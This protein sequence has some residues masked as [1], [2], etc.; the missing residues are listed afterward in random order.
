VCQTGTLFG[1]PLELLKYDLHPDLTLCMA[2]L[3]DARVV[4]HRHAHLPY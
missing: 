4:A 1:T 3:Q 2:R